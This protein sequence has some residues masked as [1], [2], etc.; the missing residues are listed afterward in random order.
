MAKLNNGRDGE[1]FLGVTFDMHHK[2]SKQGMVKRNHVNMNSNLGLVWAK[3]SLK[4]GL[5]SIYAQEVLI[6][7]Q[8]IRQFTSQVIQV[9]ESPARMYGFPRENRTASGL[10]RELAL[11]FT[12][13]ELILR[14]RQSVYLPDSIRRNFDFNPSDSNEMSIKQALAEAFNQDVDSDFVRNEYKALSE[15]SAGYEFLAV[16]DAGIGRGSLTVRGEGPA[17]FLEPDGEQLKGFMRDLRSETE[18]ALMLG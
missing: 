11:N 7:A 8:D 15:I 5:K 1:L 9:I 14:V 13:P 16:I 18:M 3:I 4:V 2:V 6:H 17:M 12:S 10:E